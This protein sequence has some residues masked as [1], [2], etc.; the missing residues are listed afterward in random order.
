[1]PMFSI[2]GIEIDFLTFYIKTELFKSQVRSLETSGTVQKS[3][4]ERQFLDLEIPLPTIKE[5]KKII[6]FCKLG[7]TNFEKIN[8]EISQQQTRLQ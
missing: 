2:K 7:K 8:I 6:A 5:Q 3:L 4:H 1:M